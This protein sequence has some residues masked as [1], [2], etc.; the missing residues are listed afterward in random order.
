MEIPK[1]LY[2]YRSLAGE[3]FKH[4][5]D[6][7]TRNLIYFAPPLSFNDPFEFHAS[8][9]FEAPDD[10]WVD[11]LA[12]VTM[13]QNPNLS[14]AKAYEQVKQ[15]DFFKENQEKRKEISKRSWDEMILMCKKDFGVLSLSKVEDHILQWSHYADGHRGICIGFTWS[16]NAETFGN[17]QPVNY[18]E[19]PS[20]NF[21][22]GT[23]E[24]KLRKCLL[25]K[26]KVW[27][28][29]QEWRSIMLPDENGPGYCEREIPESSISSVIL[30]LAISEEDRK[31]VLKWLEGRESPVAL[32]EAKM[33][34]NSYAIE[35]LQISNGP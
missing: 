12:G 35:I 33:R 18:D 10:Q 3:S 4:T 1:Q 2:K 26:A 31:R 23:P 19:F 22:E 20:F 17:P 8:V 21:F 14:K 5:E 34:P 9:S 27:S 7:L 29:E 32:Y 6:I 15:A 13:R 25:T 30:G 24:E 28:Y 16:N 11:F